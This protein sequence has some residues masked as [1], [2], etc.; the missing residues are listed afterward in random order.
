VTE[1]GHA[2]AAPRG[3]DRKESRAQRQA[4][5]LGALDSSAHSTLAKEIA[6][7]LLKDSYDCLI[8]TKRVRSRDSIWSCGRC[9]VILHQH[10][11]Q[12]WF[13]TKAADGKANPDDGDGDG[14]SA[15]AQQR[16]IRWSCPQ[17]NL[18]HDT[19]PKPYLCHCGKVQDPPFNGFLAPHSC[20]SQCG[21]ER[22][23]GCPHPCILIC[24]P[25]SVRHSALCR[26]RAHLP[27]SLTHR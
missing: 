1:L 21:R 25:G 5:A 22:G 10:C 7:R 13:R 24:H 26:C 2:P 19:P 18:V 8:C 17:C 9:F 4:E 23:S 14:D 3:V 20:G 16:Q 11:I 27:L 6:T 15:A 12:Q